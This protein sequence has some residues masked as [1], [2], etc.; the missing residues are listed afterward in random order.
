MFF[1]VIDTNVVVSS[2][3]S[4]FDDAA[5]VRVMNAV[6]DGCVVPLY[7]RAILKEYREV[8]SRPRFGLDLSRIEKV[9]ASIE[10]IGLDVD[11][12]A[13]DLPL[14]DE[15]DRVFFEVALAGQTD[16]AKLVTGNIKH[17]PKEPFVVTPAQFCEIVGI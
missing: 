2:M 10:A 14:P 13:C 12:A 17:F 15:K 5:T 4:H 16:A 3:L 1:A 9:I 7:N 6:A 11:A 8:L